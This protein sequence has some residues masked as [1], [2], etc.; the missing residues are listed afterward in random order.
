[1]VVDYLRL[2]LFFVAESDLPQLN[3]LVCRGCDQ[4]LLVTIFGSADLLAEHV[5]NV[6]FV[7]RELLHGRSL[8]ETE[9]VYLV[10]H[11]GKGV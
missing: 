2:R 8:V 3:R 4:H 10:I 7:R 5:C 1:M 9:E 6:V 11:A